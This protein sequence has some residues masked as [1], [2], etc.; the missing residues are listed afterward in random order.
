M[1][2]LRKEEERDRVKG[3]KEG[4]RERRSEVIMWIFLSLLM[5]RSARESAAQTTAE[6]Q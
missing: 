2:G 5:Y 3:G 1:V 4:E 6:I